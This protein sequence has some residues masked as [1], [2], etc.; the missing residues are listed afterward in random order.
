MREGGSGAVPLLE[1][2]AGVLILIGFGGALWWFGSET[3]RLQDFRGQ[4]EE[5][6]R[7]F[8][9]G[10]QDAREAD[11][12]RLQQGLTAL[13][14]AQTAVEQV[15]QEAE[16]VQRE[17]RREAERLERVQQEGSAALAQLKA[18]LAAVERLHQKFAAFEAVERERNGRKEKVV[19]R[20]AGQVF[21][22]ENFDRY[23]AGEMPPEWGEGIAIGQDR[24]NPK[25]RFLVGMSA[26]GGFVRHRVECPRNFRLEFSLYR[27][28]DSAYEGW[29]L[30]LEDDAGQTVQVR[31]G[32]GHMNMHFYLTGAEPIPV[33]NMYA[34][35]WSACRM[36]VRGEEVRLF[37]RDDFMGSSRV[38]GLGA[39]TSLHLKKNPWKD[40]KVDNFLGTD[41]GEEVKP[42]GK[43]G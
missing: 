17:T 4:L 33:V 21:L 8:E 27:L 9:V 6:Q 13:Q 31:Y 23:E 37:I 32:G 12:E 34:D 19:L 11:A 35:G 43:K 30:R 26:T 10:V 16:T 18:S 14:A 40:L 39:I 42:S 2:V 24:E 3:Q 1:I 5:R 28:L 25:E 38:P 20:G 36:E 22:R 7:T 41:L 15:R 29:E